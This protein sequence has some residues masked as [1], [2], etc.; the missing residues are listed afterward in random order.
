MS[1]RSRAWSTRRIYEFVRA[2]RREYEVKT[3]CRALEVTRSG[4]YGWLH[5]P[6]SM[7][8]GGR[9]VADKKRRSSNG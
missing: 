1:S 6:V 3:M 7:S 4:F 2:H 9:G 5:E 8:R